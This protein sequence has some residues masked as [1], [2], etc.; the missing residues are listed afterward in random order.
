MI[1]RDALDFNFQNPTRVR[2]GQMYILKSGQSQG[3]FGKNYCS[4]I[5]WWRG[6]VVNTLVVINK[7]IQR[8][9]QLVL[10][11]VTVRGR[12]NHLSM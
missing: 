7:V 8:R 5:R 4:F 2:I 6:V 3:G 11:W 12:V 9:A 1:N 10:G